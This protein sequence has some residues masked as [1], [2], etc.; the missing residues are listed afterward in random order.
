MKGL[1][2]N[3]I[4]LMLSYVSNIG[5]MF[6][7]KSLKILT[8]YVRARQAKIHALKE[9]HTQNLIS[10]KIFNILSYSCKILKSADKEVNLAGDVYF[11]PFK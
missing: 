1:F 9:P 10:W 3:R 6:L 5:A 7:N 8:S 4:D 2:Q 11:S